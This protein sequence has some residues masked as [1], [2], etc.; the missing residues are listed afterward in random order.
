MF[1]KV[2]GVNY[3][4]H[5]GKYSKYPLLVKEVF[6]SNEQ[7]AYSLDLYIFILLQLFFTKRILH[8]LCKP[9]RIVLVY[10]QLFEAEVWHPD[11]NLYCQHNTQT[12]HSDSHL[13]PPSS[14]SANHIRDTK[15]SEDTLQSENLKTFVASSCL[16]TSFFLG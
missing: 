10:L 11:K 3:V 15:S 1:L 14:P 6:F 13:S 5:L 8:K 4:N 12:V 9:C 7:L 16:E 2:K